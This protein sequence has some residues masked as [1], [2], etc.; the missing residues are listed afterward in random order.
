MSFLL[1]VP[2]SNSHA[3]VNMESSLEIHTAGVELGVFS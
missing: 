3:V 2:S 1:H